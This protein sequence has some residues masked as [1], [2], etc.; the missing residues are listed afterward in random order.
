MKFS[1]FFFFGEKIYWIRKKLGTN[2]ATL[3]RK[4]NFGRWNFEKGE[5]GER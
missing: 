4:E 5:G 1:F 3:F 2:E